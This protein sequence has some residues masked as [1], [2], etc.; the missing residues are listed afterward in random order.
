VTHARRLELDHHFAGVRSVQLNRFD[1]KRLSR[2]ER[3]GGADVHLFFLSP[4]FGVDPFAWDLRTATP[5]RTLP[6]VVVASMK[7]YVVSIRERRTA[8]PFTSEKEGLPASIEQ[9]D[10]S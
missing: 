9:E 5:G 10:W 8:R 2:P 4:L 7:G 3:N 6:H 1:G